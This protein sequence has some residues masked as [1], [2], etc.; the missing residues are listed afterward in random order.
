MRN[1]F[2]KSIELQK[3]R[4]NK[5]EQDLETKRNECI[6]LQ[7]SL[8]EESAKLKEQSKINESLV[9]TLADT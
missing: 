2:D 4:G 9:S 5:L 3:E 7:R 8:Q 6:Q 1:G